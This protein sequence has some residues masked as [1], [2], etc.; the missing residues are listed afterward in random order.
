MLSS[1]PSSNN[2]LLSYPRCYVVKLPSL[3]LISVAISSTQARGLVVISSHCA[4]QVLAHFRISP[5]L[6]ALLPCRFSIFS[7]SPILGGIVTT[8]ILTPFAAWVTISPKFSSPNC[9][10]PCTSPKRLRSQ[11]PQV[12]SGDQ[13]QLQTYWQD[14]CSRKTLLPNRSIASIPIST[15]AR[16]KVP[17][18]RPT[19]RNKQHRFWPRANQASQACP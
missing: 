17:I 10:T 12:V 13:L 9:S 1:L 4:N 15:R 8:M 2:L 6:V 11:A 16:E 18:R 7:L 5:K 14:F 19:I 3:R